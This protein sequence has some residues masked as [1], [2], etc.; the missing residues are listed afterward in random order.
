MLEDLF[1]DLAA[2]GAGI[3]TALLARAEAYA[4]AS[5]AL[6]LTLVTARTNRV[7]QHTYERSGWQRDEHFVAYERQ[8]E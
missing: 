6:R 7:A 4:S 2:R 8:L 5:G 3:A 1:V